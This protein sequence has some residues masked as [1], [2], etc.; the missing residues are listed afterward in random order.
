MKYT[1]IQKYLDEIKAFSYEDLK[2]LDNKFNKSKLSNWKKQ[3]YIK[4]IIRGFYVYWN[5]KIDT[6]VLFQISNKIYSPS[7]ISLES[8]FCYYSIIPEQV[9]ILTAVSTKKWVNFDSEIAYFSYKKIKSD[10]FWGYKIIKINNTKYL[11]AEI[12]KSL[13][14]YLYLKPK[15]NSLDDF[16]WLRFN[17]DILAEKIDFKKLEKYTKMFDNKALEKRVNL[18]IN[19]IHN[20]KHWIY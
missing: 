10:L 6:N 13:L 4:Q 11:I 2:I 19:Y 20:D 14:D 8:A 7:Y 3:G 18:L 12:E 17:K 1:E 9:F 15:I 16:E 5:L